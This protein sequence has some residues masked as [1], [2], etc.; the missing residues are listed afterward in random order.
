MHPAIRS[1][2]TFLSDP[3]DPSDVLA[4]PASE[5]KA[6]QEFKDEA[7]INHLLKRYGALPPAVPPGGAFDFDVTLQDGLNAIQDVAQG[8]ANLPRDVRQAYPT[9]LDLVAAVLRGEVKF[10]G[11]EVTEVP[12]GASAPSP[13]D[14][15]AVPDKT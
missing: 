4:C 12:S 10:K 3:Q 6:R 5:D 15:A 2:S 14:S 1:Q 7:N 13:S 8:Y 11:D 9:P